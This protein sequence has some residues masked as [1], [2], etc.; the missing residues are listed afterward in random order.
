MKIEG[1]YGPDPDSGEP[2]DESNAFVPTAPSQVISPADQAALGLEA[3]DEFSEVMND[4][5][6]L[7]DAPPLENFP[8]NP[9]LNTAQ[10][11]SGPFPD[12]PFTGPYASATPSFLAPGAA[13]TSIFQNEQRPSSPQLFQNGNA[14]VAGQMPPMPLTEAP[15]S[16]DRSLMQA[17][18]R[19]EED[20]QKSPLS[21][22]AGPMPS[23]DLE[24]NPFGDDTDGDQ[25]AFD[26][27]MDMDQDF[28]GKVVLTI[29]CCLLKSIQHHMAFT[30]QLTQFI[31]AGRR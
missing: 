28:K 12:D 6:N 21:A 19:R 27:D 23:F 2:L 9:F 3:H 25:N 20:L 31:A 11:M 29:P 24:G 1:F 10:A 5:G 7:P 15:S 17:E 30:F 26:M 14:G 18:M 16:G 4:I 22:A 13:A 8:N